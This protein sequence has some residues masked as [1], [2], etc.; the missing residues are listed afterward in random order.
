MK[1]PPAAP[2]ITII[3]GGSPMARRANGSKDRKPIN[4]LR[5]DDVDIEPFPKD[6]S[7][8]VVLAE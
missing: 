6:S 3:D 2:I 7:D 5:A 8:G 1:M 4:R